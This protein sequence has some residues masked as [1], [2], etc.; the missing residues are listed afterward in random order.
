MSIH[1]PKLT[2]CPLSPQFFGYVEEAEWVVE[3]MKSTGKP[4]AVTMCIGP[5]GDYANVSPGDCAVR[6]A[7]AGNVAYFSVAYLKWETEQIFIIND[8]K[9]ERNILKFFLKP[10]NLKVT[11][12]I[13]VFKYFKVNITFR[14]TYSTDLTIYRLYKQ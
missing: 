9:L 10:R 6:L 7:R 11:T 8:I 3:V 12:I 13:D 4:T 5:L 14:S 1:F 2:Y